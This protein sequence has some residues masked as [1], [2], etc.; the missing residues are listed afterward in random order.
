M[1]V[2]V[3]GAQMPFMRG[4]AE[5][6]QENLVRAFRDA[7]HDAD[8]VRLP[9][10]WDRE[11]ALDSALAWRFVPIDA[12]LVVATNFPSYFVRHP[13]K[14][15]WLFHQHRAAYDAVDTDYSDWT[16]DEQSLELQQRLV[17]WDTRALEEAQARFTTS[18]VVARRLERYNGLDA[19][20]LY[21]P[22][23]LAGELH[24]GPF[25]PV[26]FSAMRLEGNKRPELLVEAASHLDR[27]AHL[28]IAGRGALHDELVART[29]ELGVEDRITLLGFVS[30]EDLISEFASCGCVVYAPHDEDYG[31]V[32]LQAFLAG[33][34]VVTSADAGGVLEWVEDGVTGLVTDGSPRELAGAVGRLLADPDLARKLGRAG[35]ER[36]RDLD[37]ATVVRTLVESV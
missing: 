25:T 31:Y 5:L 10:A 24:E 21:H 37:W 14:V 19:T 9:V 15:V 4:G 1:R 11:R 30:D 36:A 33:K 27:G 13:R 32:T 16:L 34:P 17:D 7:G 12:D 6:H 29:R 26:A 23:P 18:R 28:R 2:C 8:L 3:C 20:P 35:W 22:P